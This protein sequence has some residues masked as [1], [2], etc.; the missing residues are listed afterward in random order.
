MDVLTIPAYIGDRGGP[1]P[2]QGVY[3]TAAQR[4]CLV[5]QRDALQAMA[6]AWAAADVFDKPNLAAP[7]LQALRRTIQ[8]A[9][10]QGN[11]AATERAL[12]RYRQAVGL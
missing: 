3:L 6:T 1:G 10:S 4:A 9:A 8:T 5:L 12:A 11:V 2:V 7:G